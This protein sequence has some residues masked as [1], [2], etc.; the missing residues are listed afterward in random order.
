M[1]KSATATRQKNR[2]QTKSK[3]RR[4]KV[5]GAIQST[6]QPPAGT[7]PTMS[8]SEVDAFLDAALRIHPW[9]SFEHLVSAATACL[10]ANGD[11]LDPK[12]WHSDSRYTHKPAGIFF[13]P[14]GGGDW[15]PLVRFPR[16]TTF[17]YC[18]LALPQ[19]FGDKPLKELAKVVEERHSELKYVD[20]WGYS[21]EGEAFH[22]Q[23]QMWEA[24]AATYLN[25]LWSPPYWP[26]S[27]WERS[28]AEALQGTIVRYRPDP[29]LKRRAWVGCFERNLGGHADHVTILY[30]QVESLSAYLNLFVANGIAPGVICLKSH[31]QPSGQQLA[32][33]MLEAFGAVLKNDHAARNSLLVMPAEWRVYPTWTSDW[34]RVHC[35]FDD[36]GRVAYSALPKSQSPAD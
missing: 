11:F 9:D 33:Q 20:H 16:C 35:R 24:K 27:K 10:D 28:F 7:K 4:P 21:W 25:S 30:L 18:D 23:M 15:Q 14:G 12:F 13:Y 19:N 26:P 3:A 17:I 22:S 29:L 1:K 6:A 36:W 34:D 31:N 5:S 32:P 2:K 8:E